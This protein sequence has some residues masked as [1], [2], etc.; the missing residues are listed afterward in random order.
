MHGFFRTLIVLLAVLM[1]AAVVVLV[2]VMMKGGLTPAD[3]VRG[4]F[5]PPLAN[6]PATP[7]VWDPVGE[8][9]SGIDQVP[10]SDRA[11][12]PIAEAFHRLRALGP[13]PDLR[14]R[15]GEDGWAQAGAWVSRE[16]VQQAIG[17]LE[18]ASRRP[19]LGMNLSSVDDPSWSREAPS[20]TDAEGGPAAAGSPLVMDMLLPHLGVI[21]WFGGVLSA[22]GLIALEAND[23]ARFMRSLRTRIGLARL[24]AEPSLLISQL[25]QVAELERVRADIQHALVHRP[26]FI[27][28]P[29]A[30]EIETLLA[31]VLDHH[32]TRD[33]AWE[34]V[35]LEDV[36]RRLLDDS[37]AY[38]PE[39]A[40]AFSKTMNDVDAAKPAPSAPAVTDF[41]PDIREVVQQHDRCSA[42]AMEAIEVPWKPMP[43][44][45]GAE[46]EAWERESA[47]ILGRIARLYFGI[48]T[49]KWDKWAAAVR[50][51]TQSMA[52]L[53]LLL[54]AHRHHLR[55][56]EP[57]RTLSDIDPDLLPFDPIDGFTGGPLH[58]RWTD[59]GPLIYA[60]GADN[61][62]DGGRHVF[63]TDG[64]PY[65][66]IT[67]QF[68]REQPDGDWLLFPAPE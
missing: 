12:T 26:G 53:R 48:I 36:L 9:N 41:E 46:I 14:V 30:A 43:E 56:G 40:L 58:Y 63:R 20:S 21:R 10:E 68:L 6:R 24:V 42:L 35:V 59:S 47:S 3:L 44:G 52:G 1:I 19:V 25:V 28:G 29:T 66:T 33:M 31:D 32:L 49:P 18:E 15:P 34:R 57:A 37:G 4:G 54:A 8:V 17:V 67:D 23:P 27:D 50:T 60:L 11:V 7:G 5:G 55:H 16:E 62:D 61:D 64:M 38:D 22:D 2:R 39:K 45:L 13:G 51:S 65:R